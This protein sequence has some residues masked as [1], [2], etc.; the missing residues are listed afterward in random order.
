[1]MIGLSSEPSSRMRTESSELEL[2]FSQEHEEP[3]ELQS[4]EEEEEDGGDPTQVNP[5]IPA[6]Q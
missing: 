5:C 2:Q 1:M 6:P 4:D 3:E